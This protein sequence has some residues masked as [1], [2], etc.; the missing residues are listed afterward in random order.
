MTDVLNN[1]L[2]TGTFK[3]YTGLELIIISYIV[4]LVTHIGLFKCSSRLWNYVD[5]VI[6]VISPSAWCLIWPIA[7]TVIVGLHYIDKLLLFVCSI[8]NYFIDK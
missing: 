4:G 7:W 6:D 1:Y 8:I 2:E 3:M 5:N